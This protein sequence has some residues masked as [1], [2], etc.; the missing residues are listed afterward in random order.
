M[1]AYFDILN[2][3]I[4]I[5]GHAVYVHRRLGKDGKLERHYYTS[6]SK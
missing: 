3:S 2:R 1:R 5:N 4:F 6:G